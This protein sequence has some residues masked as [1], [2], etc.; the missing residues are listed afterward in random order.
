M[1]TK[2]Y[3]NRRGCLGDMTK[4]FWCVFSDHSIERFIRFKNFGEIGAAKTYSF[5]NTRS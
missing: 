3:Q 1:C 2:F 5:E 4:T